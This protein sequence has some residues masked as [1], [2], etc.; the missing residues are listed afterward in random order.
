MQEQAKRRWLQQFNIAFGTDE[1]DDTTTFNGS[2]PQALMMFNGDL[3]K[4]AIRLDNDGFLA[5]TVQGDKPAAKKIE[6]L[7]LAALARK[8]TKEELKLANQLLAARQQT[9]EP[10]VD[11][12][13]AALQDI[14]WAILNSNE[15]IMN[16]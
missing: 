6:S 9:W 3:I 7:Y 5:R 11:P 16:H 10:G 13:A 15:F 4:E 8:P 14:W 12:T 2:I 1:G